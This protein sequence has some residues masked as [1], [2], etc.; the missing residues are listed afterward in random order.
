[1]NDQSF[2]TSRGR[3]VRYLPGYFDFAAR[4]IGLP[5]Q[6]DREYALANFNVAGSPDAVDLDS[7]RALNETVKRMPLMGYATRLLPVYRLQRMLAATDV[8]LP[9]GKLLDFGTG[10]GLQPRIM[11][12]TGMVREAVGLD[13]YDRA[14]SI[15]E[16]YLAQQH[17]KLRWFR[18]VDTW[19]QRI[20][21][22]NEKEWT[23][24]ERALMLRFQGP[25][26]LSKYRHGYAIAPDFYQMKFVTKPHLDCFVIE[27]LFKL[28]GRFDIITAFSVMEN[29]EADST[30]A[31]IASLLNEGGIFYMYVSNWWHSVASGKAVGHFPFASQRM[32]QEDYERYLSR[33]IPHHADGLKAAAKWY[34][35]NRPTLRDY[36]RIGAKHGLAALRFEQDVAVDAYHKKYGLS[37]RGWAELQPRV[38]DEALD[39]IHAFRPDV[40]LADLMAMNSHIV[41]KKVDRDHVI[42]PT[43][44]QRL[45]A[46]R[47]FIY[48]PNGPIGRVAKWFGKRVMRKRS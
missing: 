43:D 16:D 15:D 14:T 1:M 25:W 24:F 19:Q 47:E 2:L 29:M 17:R 48:R 22:K 36:I 46:T 27:N 23:D 5:E 45:T 41:F 35:P 8:K 4:V 12:A 13:L 21:Q 40:S 10:Y 38:L 42:S 11:R 44:Y 20:D 39:D 30:I 6:V 28:E 18:L 34:D 31:K 33:A 3:V 7:A 32:E 9:F 26:L 37:S